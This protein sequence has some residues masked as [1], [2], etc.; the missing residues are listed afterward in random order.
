MEKENKFK[1]ENTKREENK[2]CSRNSN[3]KLNLKIQKL[4]NI[5]DIIIF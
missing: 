5:I 3:I 1:E 4:C 2:F